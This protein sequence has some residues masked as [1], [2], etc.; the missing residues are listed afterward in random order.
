MVQHP[1]GIDTL[2]SGE[3]ALLPINPPEITAFI[4]ERMMN[5]LKVDFEELSVGR[6][7]EDRLGCQ[8]GG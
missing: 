3:S 6:V 5:L 1:H 4:L 2:G 8:H 7:K